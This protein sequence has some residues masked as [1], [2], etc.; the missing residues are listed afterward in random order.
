MT[1]IRLQ[2]LFAMVCVSIAA[3]DSNDIKAL[4]PAAVKVSCGDVCIRID[5]PMK[6][7]INRVEYKN[8]PLWIENSA[9]GTVF[10]FPGIGHIG[11]G[12]LVDRADGAEDVLKL[13]QW[14]D[15]SELSWPAGKSFLS[16]EL[17]LC[18]NGKPLPAAVE[19]LK[20]KSFKQH[21]ISRILDIDLDCVIELRDDRLYEQTTFSAKKS[22]PLIQNYN[23]THAWSHAFTAFLARTA[24]GN[25][26]QDTFGNDKRKDYSVENILWVAQYDAND[27]KGVI[28][29]LLEKPARGGAGLL[30]V[31]APGVYRK[32]A[33]KCF[34]NQPLPAGLTCRYRM[35]TA[36]FDAPPDK[37]LAIARTEAQTLANLNVK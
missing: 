24:D 35:V 5:G 16:S 14:L 12:H 4:G 37:W 34:T 13:R 20:G 25:E 36:F 3:A 30:L 19:S 17:Q 32:F 22:V 2:V 6:W 15:G 10:T 29:C 7:T 8:V 27:Q 9:C 28:S 11:T 23:F 31:N 1:K 26:V 21:K 33:L 18:L